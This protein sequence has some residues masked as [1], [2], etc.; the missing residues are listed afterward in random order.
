MGID[1]QTSRNDI[2]ILTLWVLPIYNW[3]LQGYS[4]RNVAEHRMNGDV[5]ENFRTFES[6][7]RNVSAPPCLHFGSQEDC[8]CTFS[9]FPAVGKGLYKKSRYNL[10]KGA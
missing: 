7:A 3:M 9:P 4:I 5:I 10:I 6:L 8:K 1:T 2:D